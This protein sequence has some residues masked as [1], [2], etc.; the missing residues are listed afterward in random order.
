MG[1]VAV[2]GDVD[3][4]RFLYQN[5]AAGRLPTDG[6]DLSWKDLRDHEREGWLVAGKLICVP[7]VVAMLAPAMLAYFAALRAEE[8]EFSDAALERATDAVES[9]CLDAGL[10][11]LA[12]GYGR[13]TDSL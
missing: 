12:G 6:I 7:E 5:F 9:A 8:S 4:A 10:K 1:C 11:S 13:R 2:I 3:I